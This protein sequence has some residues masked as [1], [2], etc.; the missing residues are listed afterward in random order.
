VRHID[1]GIALS[2][3]CAEVLGV[4]AGD[5]VLQVPRW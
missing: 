3:D 1:G 4:Q 5:E 2:R